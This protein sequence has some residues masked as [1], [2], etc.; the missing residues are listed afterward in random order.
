MI[1]QVILIFDIDGVIRDV[2]ESFRK[3]IQLTV[4]KF[5]D[6]TP[7]MEDIDEIKNEGNWNND[8]DLSIEILKRYK[9]VGHEELKIPKRDLLVKIFN[10]FYFGEDSN[11][12][13]SSTWN[14]L[15]IKEK[16]T[17]ILYIEYN[18]YKI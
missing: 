13:D 17:S 15:V 8:W 5:A 9:K 18:K 1:E 12:K 6:I 2:S 10:N 16:F 14:G 4:N 11:F 3:C 7:S